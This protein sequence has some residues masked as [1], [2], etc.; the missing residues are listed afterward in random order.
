MNDV[1]FGL[2]FIRYLNLGMIMFVPLAKL[3][4]VIFRPCT[5]MLCWLDSFMGLCFTQSLSV[6]VLDDGFVF[7]TIFIRP[8][9]G[10]IFLRLHPV[11]RFRSMYL[12]FIIRL[13]F[14]LRKT[15]GRYIL[16]S[17][18]FIRPC[19]FASRGSFWM[20]AQKI[21]DS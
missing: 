19:L 3:F 2:A 17:K 8:W 7:Y 15:H 6:H 9:L 16:A 4:P 10:R 5:G 20:N 21:K 13:F 11:L 14:L 12:R 18:D 1:P